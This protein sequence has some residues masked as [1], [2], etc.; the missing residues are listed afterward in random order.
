MLGRHRDGPRLPGFAERAKGGEQV[1]VA[2][3]LE[4]RPGPH[5]VQDRLQ[6]GRV[7]GS[8]GGDESFDE[9]ADVSVRGGGGADARRGSHRE[10]RIG[11]AAQ[12]C[13]RRARCP[14]LVHEPAHRADPTDGGL[15]VEPVAGRG[16]PRRND[17]V[18]TLPR[19]R[20]SA[21]TPARSA[22]SLMVYMACTE[23]AL[24]KGLTRMRSEG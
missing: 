21:L 19:R 8:R 15:I 14:A 3:R 11:D 1:P 5:L 4:G 17:F 7:H 22:A 10:I 13:R 24:D 12:G 20:S 6:R 23:Y 16:T 9:L 18:A 2:H